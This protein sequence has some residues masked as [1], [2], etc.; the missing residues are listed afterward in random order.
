VS[1]IQTKS[2]DRSTPLKQS[3]A[4]T[5]LLEEGQ[6]GVRRIVKRFRSTGPWAR[7]RDR[8]R[9]RREFDVLRELHA[10]GASVP[11]PF[12]LRR[13]GEAWEVA[14]EWL[15]A[16]ESLE[17]LFRAP[18]ERESLAA[19]L[20]RLL[21]R[22][23]AEGLD[24]SDLH[25]GNVLVGEDGRV[26]AIDFHVARL[27]GRLAAR[28]L[29]RDLARLAA[30]S[31]EHASP[32]FRARVLLAWWKALPPGLQARAG[33]LGALSS[34]VE[35][36]GRLERRRKVDKRRLRWT[37]EGGAVRAISTGELSGFERADLPANTLERLAGELLRGDRDAR[38]LV[39]LD[40]GRPR[41]VLLVRDDS[42]ER[43]R[44]L[45]YASARLEE[46]AVP[47]ARPLLLLTR[48]RPLA[49]LGVPDGAGF[50]D[51]QPP[52][53]PSHRGRRGAWEVGA[54]I[55]ALHDRG[56]RVPG[57]RLGHLLRVGRR[58]QLGGVPR[59]EDH[60][61]GPLSPEVCTLL[62]ELAPRRH[63]R[64]AFAC[65]YLRAQRSGSVGRAR[66]REVL[67]HG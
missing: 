45:W 4:R 9:A 8:S 32:R 3:L 65:G 54:A 28:V 25:P 24:H 43:V 36:L 52:G 15:P 2:F 19:P 56:L 46:H 18:F 31:R 22:M 62:G 12:D 40:L 13:A 6:D 21:A 39:E 33:K 55:G 50:L 11:E 30:G 7:W 41:R 10:R 53:R 34:E 49:V 66:L 60:D 5:V 44:E 35:S 67:L 64:E 59:L 16:T 38:T 23:H 37:R 14:M 61:G 63:E 29:V 20:G 26:W 51:E 48:P 1:A 57:L 58:L 42:L 47:A 17:S 27:R